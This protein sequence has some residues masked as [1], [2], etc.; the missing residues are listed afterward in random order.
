MAGRTSPKKDTSSDYRKNAQRAEIAAETQRLTAYL[1]PT[2]ASEGLFLEE[3]EI[4]LAGAHR[5]VHVIVD[6]PET[7]TGGVSLDRIAEISR[8]LSD[9]MDE[10]PH[11]DGR[12]YSLEVSSPGVSRPLTEPRH[13][14]RNTG[15][16]VTVFPVRG[17]AV[18][19]RLV[20]TDAEGI[21]VIPELPVKK[22]MKAKQGEKT[23]L[24]FSDIAKGR[25]E[26]EFAHLEDEPA[27][28]DA[29][30]FESTAEEA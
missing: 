7:E 10:D 27:G 8:V 21:T 12:P 9:A 22:G 19:G 16:M 6:L 13:W 11:D 26:I 20:E 3:I 4:K 5:T 25:V 2:V 30:E 15:R 24:A 1:A 14:R 29:D 18:T 23:H 17:D 28:E